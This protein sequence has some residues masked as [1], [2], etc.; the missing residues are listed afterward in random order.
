MIGPLEEKQTKHYVLRIKPLV[1]KR[2]WRGVSIRRKMN[3]D[4]VQH[5]EAPLYFI[6]LDEGEV[7]QPFSHPT[8]D[9]EEAISLDVE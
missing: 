5:I 3:F 8:H 6:P 1:M 9:F 7:I 4:K 2:R